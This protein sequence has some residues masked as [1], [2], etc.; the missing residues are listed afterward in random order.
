MSSLCTSRTSLSAS[1]SEDPDNTLS[2]QFTNFHLM[3]KEEI[4]EAI[5]NCKKKIIENEDFSKRKSL[6]RKLVDL[7]YRLTQLN[8]TDGEKK[9]I[10]I[11]VSGHSF[12]IVK[13]TK[14]IFCDFCSNCIWIFQVIK[15]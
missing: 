15:K 3:S 14:R 8:E 10:E 13:Q 7:R 11:N 6:V 4:S 2:H 1:D 5:E 9:P 12:R